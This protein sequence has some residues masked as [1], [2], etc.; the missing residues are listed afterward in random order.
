MENTQAESIIASM[1]IS[2]VETKQV[3]TQNQSK[4]YSTSV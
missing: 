2:R 1:E 3:D 4:N